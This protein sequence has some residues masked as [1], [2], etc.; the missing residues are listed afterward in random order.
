MTAWTEERVQQLRELLG[1]KLSAAE[2][3]AELG[4][5]SRKAVIGK[6]HRLGLNLHYAKGYTGPTRERAPRSNPQRP[7]TFNWT[8]ERIR[9]LIE[10]REAREPYSAIA[11]AVGA[12]TN[13]VAYKVAALGIARTKKEPNPAE[14]LARQRAERKTTVTTPEP[15]PD[16]DPDIVALFSAAPAPAYHGEPLSIL[17]CSDLRCRWPVRDD[18]FGACGAPVKPGK[19]YCGLHAAIAYLPASKRSDADA[20]LV[21]AQHAA[22]RAEAR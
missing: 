14:I 15:I 10:M 13:M 19:P 21:D 1:K 9:T 2:I 3:A 11:R 20:D 4:G 8:P 17:E 5:I 18:P 22:K 12:T 7:T 6:V 16:A